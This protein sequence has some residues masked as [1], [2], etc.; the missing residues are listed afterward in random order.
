MS[1]EIWLRWPFHERFN[2]VET[3]SGDADLSLLLP[4]IAA[5]NFDPFIGGG[6]P[7]ARKSGGHV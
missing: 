7:V 3:D 6:A 2:E 4:E 5:G 1:E